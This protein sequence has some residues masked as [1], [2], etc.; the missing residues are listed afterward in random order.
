M[1]Y[2]R[3]LA[4]LA[5]VLPLAACVSAGKTQTT[6]TSTGRSGDKLMGQGGAGAAGAGGDA[7]G[8]GA[9]A[10]AGGGAG[11]AGTGGAARCQGS[12]ATGYNPHKYAYYGDLHLHT[13]YSLDAYAFGTRSD[14]KNAYLFAKG[15]ATVDVE[16]A[17]T[18]ARGPH[19]TQARPID[20]LA[21]TDHAE[22]L[23]VTQGCT[24]DAQSG[25]Y[26]TSD[27][28]LVRSTKAADQTTV[29]HEIAK[30]KSTLCTGNQ[31][32]CDAQEKTAWHEIRA[33]AAE[34]YAPCRFTSLVAY[35]WSDSQRVVDEATHDPAAVT[36]HRN[37]IFASDAVPDAPLDS[38]DYPTPPKLWTG[39]EGRCT[40]AAGCD[41][42]TIPHNTNLSAGVSLVVWDPTPAGVAQQ[43]R[44]QVAAE[45]YQHK[46]ASE[47]YH[48]PAEGYADADCLFEY[49]R[50]GTVNVGPK[51]F[52]REGL[53]AGIGHA[54][55]NVS[56]GNPLKLGI[57]GGTDDHNG[58]PGNVDEAKYIG[59]AGRND[60]TALARLQK[61]PEDGSGGLTGAWAEENTRESIFA[62]VKR[63]ETFATS[64]PRISVRFYQTRDATACADPAFPAKILDAGAALPMGSTFGSAALAGASGPTFAIAVWPDAVAQALADGTFRRRRPRRRARSRSS[65]TRASPAASPS[66]SRT[67]PTS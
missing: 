25:Y 44:Y 7:T 33:A 17:T 4:S 9:S 35:E 37:V 51:S 40:A 5:L 10:G 45:I 57:V 27:C 30:S 16:S 20:F 6:G 19:I 22:W 46:A 26:N 15:Q 66:S 31:A 11:T 24:L 49:P 47:C 2:A 13:A 29:F 28:G 54:A 36:N 12:G 14:P 42:I 52:V 50:P 65:C 21:V 60:D 53:G 32:G 59:H 8:S 64:G 41:V 61:F 34:A 67:P 38:V 18:G 56:Q 48:D 43:Q 62:A 55:A 3:F 63:R 23:F 58:A 39:L 1:T